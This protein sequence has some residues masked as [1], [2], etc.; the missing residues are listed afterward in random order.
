MF[1]IGLLWFLQLNFN[2]HIWTCL[3]LSFVLCFWWKSFF[4]IVERYIYIDLQNL[5]SLNIH[6][7][8]LFFCIGKNEWKGVAKLKLLS[9]FAS[10]V[11]AIVHGKIVLFILCVIRY[12]CYCSWLSMLLMFWNTNVVVLL[13]CWCCCFLTHW[14]CLNALVLFK[15]VGFIWTHWYCCHF[16]AHWC[17]CYSWTLVLLMFLNITI[18][19]IFK[20]CIDLLFLDVV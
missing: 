18:V 5:E 8:V 13:E 17:W 15:R 2:W 12:L 14:C 4:N 11:I 20:W 6:L 10:L 7:L 1:P 9:F 3:F 16:L 19:V